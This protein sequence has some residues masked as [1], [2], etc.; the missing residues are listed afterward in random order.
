MSQV[1]FPAAYVSPVEKVV[2]AIPVH[3]PP[4]NAKT[5][6]FTPAKS[7]VVAM[8]VGTEAPEPTLPRTPCAI[9]ANPM[10]PELVMVPPV[11][12]LLVAMEVTVPW[13]VVVAMT[14]PFASTAS[15]VP[16]AAARLVMANL[17][18][19]AFVVVAFSAVKF[20][21]VVEPRVRKFV[22]KRLVA[23]RAVDDAYGMVVAPV[24]E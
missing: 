22:E 19:V 7:E 3:V 17:E 14:V 10:V 1:V 12:P 13:F 23:V 5:C 4:E 11:S 20:C 16:A 8:E 18:V 9:V 21:S 6:P 15:T 24:K 2:V